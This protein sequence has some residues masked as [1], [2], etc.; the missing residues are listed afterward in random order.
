MPETDLYEKD[1]YA[2]AQQTADAIRSGEFAKI[3]TD[4]LADE[5]AAIAREERRLLRRQL[6]V[7]IGHLLKWDYQDKKRTGSW[8]ATIDLQRTRVMELL[9]DSPSLTPW[10]VENLAG[11]YEVA[12]HLAVRDTNQGAESFPSVCPYTLDEILSLKRVDF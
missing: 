9:K 10:L 11:I 1:Y 3:D 5:V 4:A 2:W 12:V 7:L 8:A 6:E